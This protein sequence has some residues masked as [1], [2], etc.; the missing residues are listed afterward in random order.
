[1]CCYYHS[2]KKLKG[3]IVL[4]I[5]SSHGLKK[6]GGTAI[7]IFIANS[8]KGTFATFE[9]IINLLEQNMAKADTVF[10]KA[11]PT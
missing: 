9:Y 1:M 8:G 6:C 10:Q 11:I 5:T 3:V 2:P 4:S 7:M